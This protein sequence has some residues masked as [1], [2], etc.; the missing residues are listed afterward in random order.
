[1]YIGGI[2]P[3]KQE[4]RELIQLQDLP[5]ALVNTLVAVEDRAFYDHFGI[6]PRG[7]ARAIM[8]NIQSGR[9]AQGGSTLT[10]QLVKNYFLSNE[11]TLKRKAKE[12]LMAILLEIH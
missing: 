9:M 10:Q 7:I 8:T 12:A 1:M 4:D 11:R 5:P 2:F 6:S 3:A